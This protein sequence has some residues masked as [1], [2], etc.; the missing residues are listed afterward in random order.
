MTAILASCLVSCIVAVPADGAKNDVYPKVS[1]RNTEV[2]NI[3]SAVLDQEFKLHIYLPPGYHDSERLFPAVYLT[4]S[5]AYFGF[6]RSLTANLQFGNLAPA[7]VIVGIAYEEDT[8]SYLRK[9]ERDFLPAEVQGHEG[10]GNA[11]AFAGFLEEGLF[12]FV[13]SQYRVDPDDR[14]IVG[15]SGGATFASYILCTAPELFQRYIIVS[16]YFIM[17]QEIVLDLEAEYARDHD[18]LPVRVYTAMGELEPDYARKPWNA[19]VEN[20]RRR[21]YPDL[22]LEQELLAGCSHMDVVFP[23]YVSGIK[24]VFAERLKALE[25][26]PE[27]YAACTGSYDL[28]VNSK[29]FTV[30]LEHG[31]LF[32]SGSAE[33]WDE[34]SPVS[35]TRYRVEPNLDVQVSFV[36]DQNGVVVRMIIHQGGM[37]LLAEKTE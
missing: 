26:V 37:D 10:S 35:A 33:Y 36:A 11:D 19:L 14:T 13:E 24:A 23:A 32:I 5:D 28:S 9:R 21:A 20:I 15:M 3:R 30:R 4:D 12:P 1:L 7:T 17:G 2:R 22:E 25:A 6:F 16:P 18:T 31:R 27:N 8:Q 34:L 29:R